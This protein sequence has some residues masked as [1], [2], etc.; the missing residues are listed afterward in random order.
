MSLSAPLTS[1]LTFFEISGL[2]SSCFRMRFQYQSLKD[3]QLSN[4]ETSGTGETSGGPGMAGSG[5]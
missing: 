4:G 5:S 2:T 1:S 3:F